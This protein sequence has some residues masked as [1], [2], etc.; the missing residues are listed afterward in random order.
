MDP[1]VELIDRPLKNYFLTEFLSTCKSIIC[2]K[3]W[4]AAPQAFLIATDHVDLDKDIAAN[5]N[6][7]A[8]V[9]RSDLALPL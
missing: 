6:K 4:I 8:H 1:R 9:V 5:H 7:P 2:K 3:S